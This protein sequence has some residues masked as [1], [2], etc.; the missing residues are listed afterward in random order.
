MA[1]IADNAAVFH[2]VH[3]LPGNNVFVTGGCYN[4]VDVTDDFVEFYNS[5][6]IHAV[7]NKQNVLVWAIN[8]CYVTIRA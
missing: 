4:N 8:R 2:F 6:A 7:Q 3:V 1:H 5:E